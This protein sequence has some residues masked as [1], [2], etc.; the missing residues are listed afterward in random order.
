VRLCFVCVIKH[1]FIIV[2]YVVRAVGKF[3][4]RLLQP[5]H[6]TNDDQWKGQTVKEI[7]YVFTD[8]R[9]EY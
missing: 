3:D 6:L 7:L 8:H 9:H 4:I 1:E 5:K 2:L